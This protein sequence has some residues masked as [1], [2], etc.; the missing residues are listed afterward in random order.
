M[1]GI[2]HLQLTWDTKRQIQG[3]ETQFYEAEVSERRPFVR[4]IPTEGSGISKV[5]LADGKS[6]DIQD[7]KLLIQWAQD[8]SPT[9]EQD[10]AFAKIMLRKGLM[11]VPPIYATLRLFNDGTADCVVEPPKGVKKL[12]PRN[13]LESFGDQLVEGLR[14]LPYLSTMPELQRGLFVLGLRLRKGEDAVISP[15]ILRERLP[16]FSAMFQEISALP[17]ERPLVMLRF[18]LVSNFAREDRIQTF[19]TQVIQGKFCVEKEVWQ[20]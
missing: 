8:R 16:I 13:D 12:E 14:G 15:R 19:L 18:K 11:N 10:F 20:I 9:P 3:I 7:P 4:L 6:P 1:A 2:K 17:G 5:Y